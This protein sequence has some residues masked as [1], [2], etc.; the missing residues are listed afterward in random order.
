VKIIKFILFTLPCILFLGCKDDIVAAGAGALT[1]DEEV[2]VCAKTL[3]HISS[4]TTDSVNEFVITQTPDS[5]LLG[6]CNT[7]EWATIKADIMAQFACPEGFEFPASPTKELR[8]CIDS[9]A[10]TMTYSSWFAE[11]NSPL[12]ISVYEMDKATFQYTGVYSCNEDV[13]KYWSGNDSTHAVKEDQVVVAAQPSDSVYSSTTGT[14]IPIIR[15]KMSDAFVK[16]MNNTFQKSPTF[17]KQ[18]DFNESILKGLY[19][20]TTSGASTALYVGNITLVLYYHYYYEDQPG[21]GTYT[22][23]NHAKYLYANSE[24]RQVNRYSFPYR[25]FVVSA[26]KLEEDSTNYVVSPGY[27]Y[28]TLKLPLGAYADTI[29][30]A[31]TRSQS[32]TLQPYINKAIMRVDVLNATNTTTTADKWASPASD[33]LLISKDSLQSFFSRT[34]LPSSDYCLLG[35]LVQNTDDN[36]NSTYYYNFDVSTLLYNEVHKRMNHTPSHDVEMV[37]LPVFVEYSTSSTSTIVSKVKINQTITF[38]KLRSAQHTGDPLDID[39]IFSGFT[40][41]SLH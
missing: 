28:T 26:L 29:I 41:N 24:V 35:S 15:F 2:R 32:D 10:L 40:I 38:T 17:P 37:M 12:R 9:A 31:L 21:S 7:K 34:N 23:F 33:M 27:V 8:T 22:K 30:Q 1:S 16:K 18:K 19:I 13:N 11:G 3:A 39:V 20:T 5:F 6:E 36:N 14:Y 4:S 25:D